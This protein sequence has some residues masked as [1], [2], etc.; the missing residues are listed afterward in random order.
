MEVIGWKFDLKCF[1]SKQF[2]LFCGRKNNKISTINV[3]FASLFLHFQFQLVKCSISFFFFVTNYPL[4]DF[5]IRHSKAKQWLNRYG[6]IEHWTF[7]INL[8]VFHRSHSVWFF[9]SRCLCHNGKLHL[10]RTR[11]SWTRRRRKKA[12][13]FHKIKHIHCKEFSENISSA[14]LNYVKWHAFAISFHAFQISINFN[15]MLWIHWSN[16]NNETKFNCRFWIW[17]MEIR[18]IYKWFTIDAHIQRDSSI[19]VE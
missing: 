17:T 10:C 1:V 14:Q 11:W 4:P 2:L 13:V 18:K 7:P 12:I 9:D 3:S 19:D 6:N 16:N 5:A 8:F 15:G